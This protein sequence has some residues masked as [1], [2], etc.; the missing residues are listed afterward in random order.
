MGKKPKRTSPREINAAAQQSALSE[1]VVPYYFA[2]PESSTIVDAAYD[3]DTETLVV[4]FRHEN[5]IYSYGGFPHRLWVEFVNATSKGK[6]F[7]TQI[8]PLFSGKKVER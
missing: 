6:F 4:K 3:P 8:R 1:E 2:T 5:T 7:T